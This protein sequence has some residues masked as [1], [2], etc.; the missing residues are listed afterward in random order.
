MCCARHYVVFD[1]A[2]VFVLLVDFLLSGVT[3]MSFPSDDTEGKLSPWAVQ[4]GLF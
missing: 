2:S 3:S 1:H 4:C